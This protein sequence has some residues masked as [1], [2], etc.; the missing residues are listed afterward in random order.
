MCISEWA[1][2]TDNG[3]SVDFLYVWILET[4]ADFDLFPEPRH[5]RAS[6]FIY[7]QA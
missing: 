7:E 4:D 6:K 3:P 1:L 5:G 2:L